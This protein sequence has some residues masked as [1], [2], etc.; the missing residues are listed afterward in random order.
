MDN[1]VLEEVKSLSNRDL[2]ELYDLM[3]RVNHY[4]P[5][6]T[7]EE[8]KRMYKAGINYSTLEQIVLERME[9]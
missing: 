4:D 5:F 8:A 9:K 3:I 2:L 6:E 7:P 1:N